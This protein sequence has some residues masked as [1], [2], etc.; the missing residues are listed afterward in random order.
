[1]GEAL[2]HVVALG[3]EAGAGVR[4][5]GAEVA[6]AVATAA[7]AEEVV[8]EAEGGEILVLEE[9]EVVSR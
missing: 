7:K 6:V 8:V 2:D 4:M 3:E 1:V 5:G 9:G